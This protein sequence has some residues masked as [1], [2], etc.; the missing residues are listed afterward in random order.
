MVSNICFIFTRSLGK[1]SNL[2]NFFQMGWFNHQLEEHV[3]PLISSIWVSRMM[4]GP[5]PKAVALASRNAGIRFKCPTKQ[6]KLSPIFVLQIKLKTLCLSMA[7]AATVLLM[8]NQFLG[9]R[10]GQLD[11]CLSTIS[12]LEGFTWLAGR[13]FPEITMN[14]WNELPRN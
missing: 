6:G 5:N 14:R 13:G 10:I 11:F 12:T 8:D 3:R 1:W 9:M 4:R 7:V 2:T